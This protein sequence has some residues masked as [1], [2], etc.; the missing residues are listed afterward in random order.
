MEKQKTE[1]PKIITAFQLHKEQIEQA[2]KDWAKKIRKQIPKLS[3]TQK[4]ICRTAIIK[5][6]LTIKDVD[7]RY[8]LKQTSFMTLKRLLE[9]GV[10]EESKKRGIYFVKPKFQ[11][12]DEIWL[13]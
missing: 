4:D 11:D 13:E 5:G 9:E 3:P 2:K 12:A 8:I 6:K 10:I 7:K 1:S